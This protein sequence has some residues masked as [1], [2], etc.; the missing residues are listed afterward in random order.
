MCVLS[1]LCCMMMSV[2]Y[3]FVFSFDVLCTSYNSNTI[4]CCPCMIALSVLYNCHLANVHISQYKTHELHSLLSPKIP[5]NKLALSSTQPSN[6]NQRT[7]HSPYPSNPNPKLL[8]HLPSPPP[9]TRSNP[10]S[11]RIGCRHRPFQPYR[12]TTY[13]SI[14]IPRR[15][16]ILSHQGTTSPPIPIR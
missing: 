10:P 15:G 7:T 3:V 9:Q 5:I 6:Q 4:M 2:R 12:R 13:F 1:L 11:T 14:Q 16:T 8:L